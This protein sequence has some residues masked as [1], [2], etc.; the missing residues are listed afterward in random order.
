MKKLILPIITIITGFS[1][2]STGYN[3][4]TIKALNFAR[5]N[6]EQINEVITLER[7]RI[8]GRNEYASVR[9]PNADAYRIYSSYT[10]PNNSEY[11]QAEFVDGQWQVSSHAMGT[12]WQRPIQISSS[13]SY[14]AAHRSSGYG[15]AGYGGMMLYTDN[16]VEQGNEIIEANISG[17]TEARIE[18]DD[19]TLSSTPESFYFNLGGE[20]AEVKFNWDAGTIALGNCVF[21]IHDGKWVLQTDE[22][23]VLVQN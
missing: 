2:F 19:I 4:G 11:L 6:L 21:A 23:R 16:Q 13:S 22:N 7:A 5:E 15:G 12:G 3:V 8:D 10:D 17:T 20:P 18:W 1:I 9:D 14:C